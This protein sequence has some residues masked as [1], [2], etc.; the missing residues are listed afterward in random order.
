MNVA[1]EELLKYR[2][3]LEA[4]MVNTDFM[5][6]CSVLIKN[7]V[8]PEDTS[9]KVESLDPDPSHLEPDVKVR[10]ILQNVFDRVQKDVNV[11]YNLIRVLKRYNEMKHVYEALT[12]QVEARRE[13]SG[14][15]AGCRDECI[16]LKMED[17]PHIVEL[18][19]T[20]SHKWEEIGLALG[21]PE[22]ITDE[23]KYARS[24]PLKLKEIFA[25]WISKGAKCATVNSLKTAL[26][27]ETVQLPNLA[28]KLDDFFISFESSTPSKRIRL[29]DDVPHIEY[30]S[31]NN[32]IVSEGKST[33]LEVQVSCAESY[34]WIKDEQDLLDGVDFSGTCTNIL[35]INQA[36]QST[37]GKYYCRASRGSTS[38]CSNKINLSVKYPLNK[39][40]LLS[41]YSVTQREAQISWP[42]VKID[43]YIN[44]NLI[45][46]RSYSTHNF[47]VHGDLNNIKESQ[48]TEYGRVFR[49][50]K[51]GYLVLIEGRPGSGKTTLVNQVTKDWAAGKKV[52]QGAKLVFLL[53]LKAFHVSGEDASLLNLLEI[54]YGPVL[55]KNIEHDLQE[56][57]GKG[58]CFILDGVDEYPIYSVE[59]SV[60]S[61]LIYTKTFLPL[62]MVIVVSRP[63]DTH[64]I[65]ELCNTC[66]EVIGFSTKE[67]IYNFVCRYPCDSSSNFA[68]KVQKFLDQHPN[69]F[70]LCHLP[71]YATII[72][73]LYSQFGDNIPHK[74]T[75]IYEQF[76][77]A[78][79]LR[80]KEHR[81]EN[82]QIKSL[83]NLDEEDKKLFHSICKLAF[84]MLAKSQQVVSKSD[85]AV[86]FS[87][88]LA[89]GLLTVE[90]IFKH[91]G[92]EDLYTFHHV[93]FQEFL[94]AYYIHE[95]Q[96]EHTDLIK[97]RNLHN[98]WKFYCGLSL[99]NKFEFIQR[100]FKS[101]NFKLLYKIQC[102]FESQELQWCDYVIED[103]HIMLSSELITST[104]F[105][106]LG[107]VISKT[108]I[109]VKSLTI[110]NCVW[111][112]KGA[113]S[114]VS[115][116]GVEDKLKLIKNLEV[117]TE[118]SETIEALNGLLKHL[119]FIEDLD[120]SHIMLDE[121]R[122]KY[123]TDGITLQCLKVLKIT[124]P[125]VPHCSYPEEVIKL[126][127]FKSCSLERV[128]ISVHYNCTVDFAI[129]N[130]ILC[131][132]FSFK[133]EYQISWL[134][135]FNNV[136]P[137]LFLPESFCCCTE[138][139]LVNCCINFERVKILANTLNTS[140]LKKLVLDF[141]TIAD[142]GAQTLATG[143]SKCNALQELS[144]QCNCIGNVGATTLAN[145]ISNC[146]SLSKLDLQGN[147]IADEGA[148]ELAKITSDLPRLALY[149]HN[150][151]ISVEC[152]D[153]VLACRPNTNIRNMIFTSSWDCVSSTDIDVLRNALSN[154]YL[155]ALKLSGTN[156]ENIKDLAIELNYL[157]SVTAIE[158]D[159]MVDD[160][161]PNIC[162]I[163]EHL[164]SL[165]SIDCD[166]RHVI[167]TS[168]A[169]I[170]S[171]SLRRCKS[172][173]S[174]A[175]S[176]CSHSCLWDAVKSSDKL[177]SLHW[178]N[179]TS[180]SI[181]GLFSCQKFWVNLQSLV[182]TNAIC[183][184]DDVQVLSEV[185]GHCTSL[186][187]LNLNSNRI[188]DNGLIVLVEGLQNHSNLSELNL[189]NNTITSNG[190]AALN[191]VLSCNHLHNLDLS[192]N[193]LRPNGVA[194][195][196]DAIFGLNLLVLN[197]SNIKI[198]VAGVEK[199]SLG[200]KMC[201]Q[202]EVLVIRNNFIGSTGLRLVANG[203]QHCSQLQILDLAGNS[204]A[205]KDVA[206]ILEITESTVNLHKLVLNLN[207]VGVD[208]AAALVSG[209]Q[210][211][212]YLSLLLWGCLGEHEP[213]LQSGRSCCGSCENLLEQYYNNDY[214]HI[215]FLHYCLRKCIRS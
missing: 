7:F 3:E 106:A 57:R 191:P 60:I 198:S 130:K 197:L 200:L 105:I 127:K 174:V 20:G 47:T 104:D 56:S 21:L 25:R 204:L 203:L 51:E 132:A 186:Y 170:L 17:V 46:K 11:Y 205:E 207:S 120:L 107:H 175:I 168:S 12:K 45:L 128:F 118:K 157:S 144:L 90:R 80:H 121:Y 91:Y 117:Y 178:K 164:T 113:N 28:H 26:A 173:Q 76:T 193:N 30:Q 93:T 125:L 161:V 142:S 29:N 74:E 152:I 206:T 189:G 160:T 146:R 188:G 108:N 214:I 141:N 172:L 190:I 81:R 129:W 44:L 73:F 156:I 13:I 58:V 137:P 52:L 158:C 199:L 215:Q 83:Q 48:V 61:K 22:Y 145:S 195:L 95:A 15:D 38:V 70:H 68:C 59:S 116:A 149:I 162:A 97:N 71:I 159:N 54:F 19:I 140:T 75:K 211:R 8:L 64:K 192:N 88:D 5:K 213:A 133:G 210:H 139:V 112:N 180:A 114:L 209:W 153:S 36:N 194:S 55:S 122:V 102:A 9:E 167:S 134:H 37:Q 77:I 24:N 18:L 2:S 31:Y 66:I 32:I 65:K 151:Y 27:S 87:N 165:Q 49:E 143:L 176:N 69:V 41:F 147:N 126:L 171:N 187:C 63:I 119:P 96:L 185:L 124:L 184:S 85:A 169:Q 103:G 115:V 39:E 62:S 40:E 177:R 86:S 4:F 6:L 163:M 166:V 72:C 208:G 35:Y 16:F 136:N 89:L 150:L 123:L 78:T 138:V 10:Y 196:T 53:S 182:L 67:H 154:C 181:V 94:A 109:V 148:I 50:Y 212:C 201:K 14:S 110:N 98:V 101:N 179:S 131:T 84:D 82:L 23:C 1:V 202:L 100:I 155:P 33:L 42:P 34:Q 79:L 111:D 135:L 183:S 99:G 92:T 43:F